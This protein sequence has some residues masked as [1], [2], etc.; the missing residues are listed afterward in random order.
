MALHLI[1]MIQHTACACL[2][3]S[4]IAR[5]VCHVTGMMLLLPGVQDPPKIVH[6]TELHRASDHLSV[7]D[8]CLCDV[9]L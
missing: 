9:L 7:L 2:M 5:V 8:Y 1:F 6:Y 3:L 4:G